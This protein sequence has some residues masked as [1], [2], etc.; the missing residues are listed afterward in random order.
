MRSRSLAVAV[1]TLPLTVALALPALAQS[2]PCDAYSGGCP[3]PGTSSFPGDDGGAGTAPARAR[4]PARVPA[5]GTGTSAGT[6]SG[7]TVSGR[8][9]SGAAPATLPFTGGE[10]VLLGLAGLGAVAAGTAL[11]VVGRRRTATT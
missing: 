4:V 2:A 8:S 7:T 11:V 10:T 5:P 9:S 3:S 1:A 6:V